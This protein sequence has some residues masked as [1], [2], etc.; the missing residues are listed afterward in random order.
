MPGGGR[1]SE[2]KIVGGVMPLATGCMSVVHVEFTG[3]VGLVIGV[4]CMSI[5]PTFCIYM[6]HNEK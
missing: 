5:V 2:V 4:S 3:V 1:Q 6:L